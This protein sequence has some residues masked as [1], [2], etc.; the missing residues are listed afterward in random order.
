MR[1]FAHAP[2]S[3]P[4]PQAE[5]DPPQP[6]RRSDGRL[7]SWLLYA[8][9]LAAFAY[10]VPST[11]AEVPVDLLFRYST[12][13]LSVVSYALLAVPVL[14]ILR[15]QPKRELLGLR[16]PFS[17]R[18]AIG[19]A[20]AIVVADL[21]ATFAYVS[22]F[23]GTSEAA[24]PVFWDGSR[25]GQFAATFVALAIVAPVAEEL[26]YRGVGYGLLQRFGT[27]TA[28]A[29]TGVLF[30]LVHGYVIELPVF[31]VYGFALGWLRSRTGSVYPGMLAHGLTNGIAVAAAVA[32]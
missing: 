22:V 24:L 18:W 19:L 2:T 32:G 9:I 26:M 12:A 20:L 1:K 16:P 7:H 23:V 21:V 25:A 11:P 3:A 15:G 5:V 4:E 17:W 29:A 8:G 27:G 6:A 13:I 28:I 10:A 31:A 30:G 14:L